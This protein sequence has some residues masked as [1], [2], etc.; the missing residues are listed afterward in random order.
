MRVEKIK[1]E[2]IKMANNQKKNNNG[3]KI[4]ALVLAGLMVFSAVAGA[5]AILF[6]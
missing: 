6:S 2:D 3:A 4:M 5:L 1:R